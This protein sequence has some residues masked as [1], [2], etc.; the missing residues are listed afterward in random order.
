MTLRLPCSNPPAPGDGV[1]AKPVDRV[2]RLPSSAP[3][4]QAHAHDQLQVLLIS[5][6]E[7][8][9][10]PFGLASSAAWVER[11]GVSV[12]SVD[13]AVE[14]LPE[15]AVR[16][17]DL[18]GFYVPMHTA[19]S[20]ATAVGRHVRDLK[21]DVHMCFFGLYE[22]VNE[23]LPMSRH[24]IGQENGRWDPTVSTAATV[25]RNE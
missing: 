8:S 22:P 20:I 18:V 9:R 11:A 19:G 17:A 23:F 25:R 10:Q 4:P 12:W 7:L 15:E 21:P 24:D 14:K 1:M 3:C 16:E 2:A 13:L 6:H 5:T